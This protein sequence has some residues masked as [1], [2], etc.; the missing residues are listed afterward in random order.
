MFIIMD[1]IVIGYYYPLRE[2]QVQKF[3]WSSAI[4]TLP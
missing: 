1:I 3:A 2:L 4:T